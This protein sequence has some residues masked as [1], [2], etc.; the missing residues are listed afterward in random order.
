MG[1][2]GNYQYYVHENFCAYRVN[3]AE[4]KVGWVD[5]TPPCPT[6]KA[7]RPVTS[8]VNRTYYELTTNYKFILK[9]KTRV[10]QQCINVYRLY[11]FLLYFHPWHMKQTILTPSQECIVGTC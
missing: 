2:I 7:K 5:S 3:S 1:V 10:Y 11:V 6:Q 9:N 4:T 8:R